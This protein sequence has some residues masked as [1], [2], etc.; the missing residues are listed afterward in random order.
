MIWALSHCNGKDAVWN[1][2]VGNCAGGSIIL[3]IC[4]IVL[5]TAALCDA[6]FVLVP[7]LVVRKLQMKPRLK[8]TLMAVMAMGSL[9]AVFSTARLPWVPY[10]P[11]KYGTLCKY[12]SRPR[13]GDIPHPSYFRLTYR[14]LDQGVFMCL[15]S[16][17]ENMI[18]L[19]FGS[20]PAIGKILRLYDRPNK[21]HTI[22][23][24]ERI[25]DYTFGGTPFTALDDG[26]RACN[27]IR[28]VPYGKGECQTRIWSEFQTV[29]STL[30]DTFDEETVTKG[31][32]GIE[33]HLSF[34]IEE[35]RRKE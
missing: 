6:G 28:L 26:P 21:S 20:L 9:A 19:V 18:G 16:M 31:S 24:S 32:G 17:V 29:A 34:D 7:F 30:L 27:Q 11:V 3:P 14:R 5:I 15:L 25:G 8:Y 33:K 2:L 23:P 13:K 22:K 1:S 10:L 35:E 4:Y 12:P